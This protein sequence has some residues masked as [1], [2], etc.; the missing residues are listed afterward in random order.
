MLFGLFVLSTPSNSICGL[1]LK[2]DHGDSDQYEL[3]NFTLK[4]GHWVGDGDLM[5]RSRIAENV[6]DDS[7]LKFYFWSTD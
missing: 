1:K 2:L 6:A 5:L 3:G 4:E 7:N